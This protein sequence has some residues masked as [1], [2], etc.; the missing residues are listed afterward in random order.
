M[1]RRY[2]LNRTQRPIFYSVILAGVY[3]IKNLKQKIRPEE[4]HQYNSPWNIA[5]RFNIDTSFSARQIA[6]MIQ[7]YEEDTQTGMS[8]QDISACIYEYTSGYPYLVS[9]VCKI[10]DGELPERKSF[11]KESNIWTRAGVGEAI[12]VILKEISSF[13][14]V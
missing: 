9:A 10:M 8:V 4:K 2:Y 12:K 1:L 5:A 11:P 14:A 3:D 6:E 13:S 7:E